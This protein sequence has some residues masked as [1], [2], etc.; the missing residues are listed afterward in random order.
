MDLDKEARYGKGV[1]E[2]INGK[3]IFENRME[4][5]HQR[6][7]RVEHALGGLRKLIWVLQ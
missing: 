4:K 6:R 5:C 2:M 7:D 3:A 1:G